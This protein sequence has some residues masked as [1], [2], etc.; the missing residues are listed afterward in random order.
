MIVLGTV[1]EEALH[2]AGGRASVETKHKGE[3][4]WIQVADVAK[5]GG[6]SA[7]SG[8]PR[9]RVRSRDRRRR[10]GSRALHLLFLEMGKSCFLYKNELLCYFN[11]TFLLL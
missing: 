8:R 7:R 6:G 3:H 11:L 9:R 10:S 5:G 4:G 2:G 1:W